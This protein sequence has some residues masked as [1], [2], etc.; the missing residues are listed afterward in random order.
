M[1]IKKRVSQDNLADQL[2]HQIESLQDGF[3][4]LSKAA[5][6]KDLAVQFAGVV[7]GMFP[8]ADIDL[9]YRPDQSEHWQKMVDSGAQ[10]VE[11]LLAL[12][13]GQT[14]SVCSL[15]KTSK[16]ICI[17]QRLVDK[18]HLSMVLAG[19]RTKAKHSELDVVSLRLFIH[20]FDN[21]YQE[22]IYRR[23]EKQLIFSLNHR[24]LQLN[25]LIDTGIEVSKLDQYASPQQLALERA[26]SLTNASKGV[27][28]VTSGDGLKEEI[29][30]PDRVPVKRTA[31]KKNRIAASF[32][33]ADN[34]YSFE[35][36]EKESRN[37]ILP[38]EETDQLLLDALARQVHASLENRY[39]HEQALEKQKIERDIAVAAAIQ[40]RILP[41]SLPTIKGY[42][43]AGIN[44]PSKSVGGDYYDCIPLPGGKYAL[45]IADVAGKG[46]PAALLVS[47]LH[48]YLSAYLESTIPLG[49]L[50]QRLNK[51]IWRAS[52]DDKFITAL[53]A[54]LS[55]ETGGLELLNAGHNPA[56]LVRNEGIV[57]DFG[58]VG[59]PLGMLDIDFHYRSEHVTIGK[60][61]RLLLYTD[62]IT[63]ASDEHEGFYDD[64]SPLREFVI[65]HKPDRAEVFITDLIS[66]IKKF[67]GSAPQSDDITALYLHRT[68]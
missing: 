54:L 32:S 36:F 11:K 65:H 66:D 49:Q 40:K 37:G 46:I 60:G 63:E 57:Q 31:S 21:A 20:L 56:Y 13:P 26:A 17:V 28:R 45:I 59:L 12:P 51:A 14:S 67:T 6:L 33:F 24:V 35:L 16:S 30:F 53:I 64:H 27:L 5:T 19:K 55:P 2:S 8:A 58:A 38:F 44:I 62:G 1:A 18:S 39:L 50:A 42:D 48:A 43:I 3:Q 68:F 7:Q 61:E 34:T 25:S 22:L 9:L 47:S 4:K 29:Y 52:T 15:Y 10:G 23:N 41:T